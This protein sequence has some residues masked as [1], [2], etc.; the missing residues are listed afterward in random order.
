MTDARRSDTTADHAVDED[1]LTAKWTAA[2]L[3]AAGSL[4][5]LFADRRGRPAPADA[6]EAAHARLADAVADPAVA[7]LLAVAGIDAADLDGADSDVLVE[8]VAAS[9]RESEPDQPGDEERP[10]DGVIEHPEWNAIVGRLV[11]DGS[12][13]DVTPAA[14]AR[15]VVDL[16]EGP[17]REDPDALAGALEGLLPAWQAAGVVDDERRLTELGAWLLPRAVCRAWGTDFDDPDAQPLPASV[18]HGWIPFVE[19]LGADEELDDEDAVLRLRDGQSVHLPSLVANVVATHRLT[20]EEVEVDALAVDTDLAHFL[21]LDTTDLPVTGGGHAG[22]RRREDGLVSFATGLVGPAGWLGLAEPGDLVAIRVANGT[23]SVEPIDE[24]SVDETAAEATAARLAEVYDALGGVNVV[25][26]PLDV[27]ELMLELVGRNPST[28]ERAQPPL[29]E[30]IARTGLDV[31]GCVV[32]RPGAG[33]EPAAH[34]SERS[35]EAVAAEVYGLDDRGLDAHGTVLAAVETAAVDGVDALGDDH[36]AELAAALADSRVA[37]AVGDA[38][39]GAGRGAPHPLDAVAAAVGARVRDREAAPAAYLRA[40]C[41]EHEGRT[42]DAEAHLHTALAADPDFAPALLEAAWYAE[43]RGE[44]RR[45]ATWLRRAG[46]DDDDPQ[47]ARLQAH[48]AP[49]GAGG[50]VGRN[51]PC[52]CGS[53]RKFKKCCASGTPPLAHRADWLL[54]KAQAYAERP[55]QR[56]RLMPIVEARAGDSRDSTRLL[57]ALRGSLVIDLALFEGGLLTAFLDE[58][59]QL[60]PADEAALARTWIATPRGVYDVVDIG[61]GGQVT[62]AEIASGRQLEA[63]G[64]PDDEALQPGGTIAARLVAVDGGHLLTGGV[65]AVPPEQRETVA[66]WLADGP[67]GRVQAAWAAKLDGVA[68]P[69]TIDGDPMALCRVVYELADVEAARRALDARYERG[70]GDVWA[71]RATAGGE[72]WTLATL[73]LTGSR[74]VVEANS[75]GRLERVRAAVAEAVPGAAVVDE[76]DDLHPSESG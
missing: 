14:L 46:V 69:V 26:G 8:L 65:V 39:L 63:A 43:D 23:L 4:R 12:G 75:T 5:G 32:H 72:P 61:S 55:R 53:G 15:R 33:P 10:A 21:W 73:S 62:L 18:P 76:L 35:D 70:A 37:E 48:S 2:K 40:R 17:R 67:D 11:V 20:A 51:D 13:A 45:A 57:E 68:E 25:G 22:V 54:A 36:V 3:R 71:D 34:E 31:T 41:A 27:P 19:D 28:L 1:W 9:I 52:P 66:A 56:P 29:S 6:V 42:T 16:F 60:L 59:G 47:L 38:V 24:G 64:E 58:R 49:P 74:L 7:R 30:L 50:D 44:A